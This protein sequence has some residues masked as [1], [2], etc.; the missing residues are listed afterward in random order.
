M[1]SSLKVLK[2]LR[3]QKKMTQKQLAQK[4][5]VA[6]NTIST[7]EQGNREP[8]CADLKDL[9]DI[10]NVSIDFLLS[11]KNF[12]PCLSLSKEQERLLKNFQDLDR[13]HQQ[14][15]LATIQAFLTE[16]ATKDFGSVINNHNN[17]SGTFISNQGD[18]CILSGA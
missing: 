1:E 3:R 17:S 9:A 6:P 10:F 15:I 4:M 8:S 5:R 12:S 2:E 11:R 7:W 18:N 13:L 16:Q 14:I